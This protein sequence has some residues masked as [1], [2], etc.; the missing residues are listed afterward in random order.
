MV[1][2]SSISPN[3]RL[4]E[5]YHSSA[6][7]M[8]VPLFALASADIKISMGLLAHAYTAP[9]TLGIMIGYVVGKPVG[10]AGAVAGEQGDGGG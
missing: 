4:Q 2:Q 3:E 8:I 6:S 5:R 10:T 1:V 9:A 7:Y